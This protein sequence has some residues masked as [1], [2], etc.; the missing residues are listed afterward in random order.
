VQVTVFGATGQLGKVTVPALVAAGHDVRAV[1]RRD[2]QVTEVAAQG[3]TGVLLDL[4]DAAADF[5]ALYD[6]TDAVVWIAGANVMTGADHSDRVDREGALRAIAAAKAAG[7]DRWLQVSSMFANRWEQ[8]PEVLH[9]FLQ[10]KAAADDAVVASGLTWTVLRPGGL[11]NDEPT[12]KIE[13]A[14]ELGWGRITRP[15]VA[16]VIVELLGSGRAKNRAFDLG[17]GGTPIAEA[18][19]TL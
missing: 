19:A 2:D 17:N 16:A 7:V 9:H 4:E 11:A 12:G 13:V 3:A 18:L 6:G 10:N 1:V 14:D 5:A 8:G 15:D